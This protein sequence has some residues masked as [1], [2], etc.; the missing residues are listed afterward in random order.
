MDQD[1]EKQIDQLN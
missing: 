1:I